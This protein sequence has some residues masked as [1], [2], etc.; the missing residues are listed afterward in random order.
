MVRFLL[1]RATPDE[2]AAKALAGNDDYLKAAAPC[3]RREVDERRDR[4][5]K[6]A[7]IGFL[8]ITRPSM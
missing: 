8:P 5:V 7:F 6:G 3:I 1:E 4:G 2:K